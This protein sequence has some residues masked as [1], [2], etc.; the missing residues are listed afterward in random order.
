MSPERLVTRLLSRNLHLLA[1]RISTHLNLRPDPVMRHWACAK[2]AAHG[3][4]GDSAL[5]SQPMTDDELR[6]M[7]VRKFE[8]E[9]SKGANYAEIAKAAW[10]LGRT[11]L[12][13]KV[14]RVWCVHRRH[15]ALT[16][17]SLSAI[18]PRTTSCRAGAFA[19]LDEGRSIGFGES[20]RFG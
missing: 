19:A 12:A 1:L 14:R 3:R 13:T 4:V 15:S 7:I 20:D 6:K 17:V 2:I 10:Q 16:D 5:A 11:K 8:K 18:G 9:G